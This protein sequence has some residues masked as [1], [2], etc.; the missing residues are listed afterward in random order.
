MTK[1]HEPALYEIRMHGHLENR[2]VNW[3]EGLTI[4]LTENGK[5]V[6]TGRVG[7]AALYG[8]LRKSVISDCPCT[9]LMHVEADQAYLSEASASRQGRRH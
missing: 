7:Q 6:I 1:M 8:A 9:R 3:F 2:W 4:R 5:T